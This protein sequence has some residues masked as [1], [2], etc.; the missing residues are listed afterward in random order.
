M[1]TFRILQQTKKPPLKVFKVEGYTKSCLSRFGL[2]FTK[3]KYSLNFKKHR[4]YRARAFYMYH[5]VNE[6]Y[7][8]KIYQYFNNS[9]LFLKKLKKREEMSYKNII[10][11]KD[12]DHKLN[13]DASF[14][15]PDLDMKKPNLLTSKKIIRRLSRP[16]KLSYQAPESKRNLTEGEKRELRK[17]IK[18]RNPKVYERQSL[19]TKDVGVS[20]KKLKIGK[21]YKKEILDFYD[22][23]L[24][25][26]NF[27]FKI[28]ASK[29]NSLHFQVNKLALLLKSLKLKRKC[30][31]RS[32]RRAI[33]I[34]YVSYRASIYRISR[35][36]YKFARFKPG[37]LFKFL[38]LKLKLYAKS[39][40]NFGRN[41]H[42]SQSFDVTKAVKFLL[43]PIK[44]IF[45]YIKHIDYK[46]KRD[47]NKLLV[48][49]Y[50]KMRKLK[51]DKFK[52]ST[53]RSLDYRFALSVLKVFKTGIRRIKLK[54]R[55]RKSR[56]G[57]ARY[58]RTKQ[59]QKT[60]LL[61]KNMFD[62]TG[63]RIFETRGYLTLSGAWLTPETVAS[64]FRGIFTKK[65]HSFKAENIF[66]AL[67]LRMKFDLR[68]AKIKKIKRVKNL[69]IWFLSRFKPVFDL[70][71]NKRGATTIFE[72]I[73]LN[74]RR[75]TGKLYRALARNLKNRRESSV[76]K[77]LINELVSTIEKRS[78]TYK[79]LTNQ[80]KIT[81]ASRVLF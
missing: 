2:S 53:F 32:R 56:R 62:F 61:K 81:Y 8:K 63:K 64:R 38:R 70:T 21:T 1:K 24:D 58:L 68:S 7:T 14:E 41:R 69:L 79:N 29:D 72:P 26:D 42:V 17:R 77:K 39:L 31:F 28:P 3:A 16:I 35:N 80:S 40:A 27:K 43:I 47:Q 44:L 18:G 60:G 13:D 55:K 65:G 46:Q 48:I 45:S 30:Y 50:L 10:T 25:I 73:V 78:S 74:M 9:Y 59:L 49:N 54:P 20:L 12:I 15:L 11:L 34:I 75:A 71:P 57:K 66:K 36:K 19:Y 5:V 51:F 4:T 37:N 23:I 76:D 22:S 52:R 33:K 6:N 67:A